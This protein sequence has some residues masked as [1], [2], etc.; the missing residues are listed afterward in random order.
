[1]M[2]TFILS[3][4]I[5][6]PDLCADVYIDDDGSPY[7]D[8]LGQTFSRYCQWTGPDAPRLDADLCCTID[9]DNSTCEFPDANDRCVVGERRHCEYGEAVADG[10]VC[11]QPFPGACDLGFCVDELDPVATPMGSSILCCTWQGC[12]EI[13]AD[14][15]WACAEIDGYSTFCDGGATNEDGTVDCLEG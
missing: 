8:G 3:T 13:S 9:G 14:M 4:L 15:L 11:Y 12:E 7:T 10:A 2:L 5:L 6:A 1:M